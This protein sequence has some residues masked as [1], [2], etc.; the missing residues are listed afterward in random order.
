VRCV[1]LNF[2]RL[3]LQLVHVWTI[4][5]SAASRSAKDDP[6]RGVPAEKGVLSFASALEKFGLRVAPRRPALTQLS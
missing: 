3:A 5:R 1:K 2:K 4:A 6:Y